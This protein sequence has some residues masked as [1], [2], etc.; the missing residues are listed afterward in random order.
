MKTLDE[1]NNERSK[2]FKDLKTGCKNG[3]ECPICGEE[4][5]DGDPRMIIAVFP[6]KRKIYCK[7]CKFVDY[8]VL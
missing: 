6:P 5:W 7:S 4:M 3:I 1:Y 2:N 8:K